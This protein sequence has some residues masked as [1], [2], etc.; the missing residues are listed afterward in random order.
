MMLILENFTQYIPEY[1]DLMI[2]AI[3]FQSEKGEDWY[4]HRTRF[5]DDTL[6]VCYDSEGVIR[7]FGFDASRLYPG[8][9]SVAEVEKNAV[10]EDISING[11][12]MFD[13]SSI[14]P[15]TYTQAERV[16]LANKKRLSLM[17][18]AV[19]EMSPLSDAVELGRAT[20]DQSARLTALKNYRLDLFELDVS[21]ADELVWPRLHA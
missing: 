13:G 4:F 12:W 5:S 11:S 8:G 1:A 19:A 20:A 14:V 6:K 2:P 16:D 7:S 21:D 9:Y 17:A 3:Y 10:P 15:R 18:D